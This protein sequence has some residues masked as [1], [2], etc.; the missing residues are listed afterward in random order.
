MSWSRG[1]VLLLLSGPGWAAG[2]FVVGAGGEGDS[3][4]G[5]AAAVFGDVALGEKTWLAASAAHTSV[6]LELRDTLTTW[7]TDLGLDHNFGPLGIRIGAAYWGDSDVLDSVDGRLAAY[8]RSDGGYLSFNYEVRNFELDLPEL[9]I[10]PRREVEFDANGFGLSGRLSL[11]D[12]VGAHFGGIT[13]DYSV[14]L[15]VDENR[16]IVDYISVSRLSLVTSLVDYRANV[17]IGVDLGSRHLE[18]DV[19]Q[20]RGAVT[21]SRTNSYSVR[22]LTPIGNRSDVEFGLGY[23]D[24]ERFGEATIFSVFLYFYGSG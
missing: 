4:D 16:P 21:G 10:F 20:W 9:D 13:Y 23:D 17:G 18:F 8:V 19:A 5:V 14:D 7:Y 2:E 22:F 3:L 15:R 6:D 12:N 11:T 24:S 1:I